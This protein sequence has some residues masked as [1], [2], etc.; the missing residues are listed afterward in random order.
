CRSASTEPPAPARSLGQLPCRS[1]TSLK[2]LKVCCP[3]RRFAFPNL[4]F[5]S[6]FVAEDLL[7]GDAVENTERHMEPSMLTIARPRVRLV[8]SRARC[9]SVAFLNSRQIPRSGCCRHR[10]L[11]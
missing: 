9:S 1:S 3:A 5:S 8:L 11:Y 4:H 2:P 10:L 6:I 7:C